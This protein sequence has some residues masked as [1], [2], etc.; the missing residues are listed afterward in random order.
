MRVAIQMELRFPRQWDEYELVVLEETYRRANEFGHPVNLQWFAERFNR[1]KANCCRKARELG[2]TDQKRRRVVPR[3]PQPPLHSPEELRRLRSEFMKRRHAEHGHPM[4]GRKHSADV[5]ERIAAASAARW[6]A[7]TD[8][9]KAAR[10]MKIAQR[11]AIAIANGTLVNERRGVT[12]KGG[13]RQVGDQRKYFRSRW[14]ANYACYL[15]WLRTLGQIAKWEHEAHTFWFEGIKRGCVSYLPDFKV[16]NPSGSVEWHEVKGWMDD[17]S[18]TVLRRMAKYHPQE[19]LVVIGQKQ[20]DEIRKKV[21]A[22]VPGW[23][24]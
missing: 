24:T 17:R 16:T 23:E 14:E 7:M 4:R 10:T 20:Y 21:A 22:L 2:L 13:W 3:P 8:D 11:R 15:E 18:K 9:Q 19:K 1:D 5:L 12:W 6:A